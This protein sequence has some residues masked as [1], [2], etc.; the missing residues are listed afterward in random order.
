MA[1]GLTDAQRARYARHLLL[2]ELG[3]LGQSRLLASV[4]RPNQDADPGA[5]EVAHSYLSRAGLRIAMEGCEGPAM[6]L[7]SAAA[8]TR[9]AG[10]PELLEAARLLAGA[11][12]AVEAIK[13]AAGIGQQ[14]QLPA[15]FSLASEEV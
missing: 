8:V 5:L 2:P 11:F 1:M 13:A 14:S 15:A 10:A 3:E 12:A 6:T 9:V 7:A 4:V